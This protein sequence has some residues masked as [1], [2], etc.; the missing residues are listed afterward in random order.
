MKKK[1]IVPAIAAACLVL[2][3]GLAAAGKTGLLFRVTDAFSRAFTSADFESV[4]VETQRFTP[5]ELAGDSRVTF[6]QSGMLVNIQ[7]MLPEDYEAEIGQY[8]DTGV[9]MNKA[10]LSAYAELSA[11][12]Q[13]RF[14]QKLFVRS[15][16]RTAQEQEQVIREEGENATAVGASEHQ[17]GLALDVYV[18]SYAG[19]AFLKSE[20]GRWVNS[21]CWKYGFI[22]R[23]PY[24]KENVDGIGYEPWHIRY[25][26]KPHAEI[27][28]R[29]SLT[30]E[31]YFALL[32]DGQWRQCGNY[33]ISR[34]TGGQISLP[35]EF[36]F[37]TVSPDNTGGY[38]VTVCLED[39]TID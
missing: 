13:A 29:E 32:E 38:L 33:R 22:I 31:E 25:I 19:A 34:Q 27:L 18:K 24:Y 23:Y 6:D 4:T 1:K 10:M 16:Y 28:Y 35:T 36:A 30:L 3:L 39:G 11:Q 37:A 2:I 15:S 20:V 21:Q 5:E 8:K 12:V 7:N 26:G 14:G 17:T 9:L